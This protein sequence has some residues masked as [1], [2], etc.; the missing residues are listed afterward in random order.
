MNTVYVSDLLDKHY[1]QPVPEWVERTELPAEDFEVRKALMKYKCALMNWNSCSWISAIFRTKRFM[2]AKLL[3]DNQFKELEKVI[4]CSAIH[5][6]AL[7]RVVNAMPANNGAR[8]ALASL[9]N[10]KA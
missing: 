7:H 9:L 4:S 3:H 2:D 10:S 5:K 8:K 6:A 1:T